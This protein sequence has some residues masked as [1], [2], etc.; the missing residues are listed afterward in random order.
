MK[1]VTEA[2]LVQ[3][4]TARLEACE[5]GRGWVETRSR[6]VSWV[7]LQAAFPGTSLATGDVPMVAVDGSAPLSLKDACDAG[8]VHI[9]AGSIVLSAPVRYPYPLSVVKATGHK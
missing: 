2:R 1:R 5:G 4:V 6:A 7:E 8:M 3:E 9:V